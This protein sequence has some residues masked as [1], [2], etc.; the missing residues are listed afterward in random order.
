MRK[1]FEWLDENG[2][3]YS[4][5]AT[6]EPNLEEVFLAI[7]AAPRSLEGEGQIDR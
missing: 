5:F 7:S 3:A 2:V 6:S 1:L 4:R